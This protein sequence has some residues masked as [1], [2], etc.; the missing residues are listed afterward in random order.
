MNLGTFITPL[1]GQGLVS[2]LDSDLVITH[3]VLIILVTTGI[4]GITTHGI[5]RLTLPAI[6]TGMAGT[7][8]HTTGIST[9]PILAGITM[10]AGV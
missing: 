7:M 4:H 1:A 9:H 2:T 5:T 8:Q 3:G 10:G 6:Y